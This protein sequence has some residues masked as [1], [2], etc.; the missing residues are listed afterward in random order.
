M[1]SPEQIQFRATVIEHI[2]SI[3]GI[4]EDGLEHLS[5]QG[6]ITF[7]NGLAYSSALGNA[8]T[9]ERADKL[10]KEYETLFPIA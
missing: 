1:Y 3:T 10:C 9:R 8:L 5:S 2:E 7:Y 6:L 4:Y